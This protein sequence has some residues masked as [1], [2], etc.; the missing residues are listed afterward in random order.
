MG[1]RSS[2]VAAVTAS[3]LGVLGCASSTPDLLEVES[4]S[5]RA[6]EAR[7]TLELLGEGFPLRGE[8]NA[9]FEG[10]VHRAGEGAVDVRLDASAT[11][12]SREK[13]TLQLTPEF[14][15]AALGD[16]THHGTF[17]GTVR[18]SFVPK[19]PGAPPITGTL[20][21]VILDL[22]GAPGDVVDI[23]DTAASP[24]AQ[25]AERFGW[26]LERDTSGALCV[27]AIEPTSFASPLAR[28]DCF[29]TFEGVNVLSL[30]DL[31][32]SPGLERAEVSIRRAGSPE[33]VSVWVD[34]ANLRPRPP[35]VWL[36]SLVGAC[37]I[38]AIVLACRGPLSTGLS[39]VESS[40]GHAFSGTTAQ[41]PRARRSL[42]GAVVPFASVSGLFAAAGLGLS[43][44]FSDFDLLLVYGGGSVLLSLAHLMGGGRTARGGFRIGAALGSVFRGL[45]VHCIVLFTLAASVMQHASL[46][47]LGTARAQGALLW[48]FDA[49]RSPGAYVACVTLGSTLVLLSLMRLGAP[50]RRKRPPRVEL[51][52]TLL[53]TAT[54][55]L[56]GLLIV[57]YLG[58]WQAP[59]LASDWLGSERL[60]GLLT[61]QLK[62]TVVFGILTWLRSV[63]PDVA[64]KTLSAVFLRW[65]L[66]LAALSAVL[67]LIWLSGSWPDWLHVACTWTLVGVTLMLGA[68]SL[69]RLSGGRRPPPAAVPVNPW[70]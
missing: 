20:P 59:K 12:A 34:A 40:L 53:D 35:D 18:L 60:V 5:P 57:T 13:A 28:G 52:Q 2:R 56:A 22:F 49:F 65:L 70:L 36:W 32:P 51:S 16:R 11:T 43:R 58:G 67:D 27:A 69:L 48:E 7:D 45:L 47:M 15:R 23:E 38:A 3:L 55:M 61:F 41:A 6:I 68:S 24:A 50:R 25:L 26:T 37:L 14:V 66:P 10:T 8:A 63:L 62:L 54:C 39:L 64:D 9:V 29:S 21:D 31:A 1:D 46:S 4:I 19:T 44:T 30:A 42:L 17:R 33:P